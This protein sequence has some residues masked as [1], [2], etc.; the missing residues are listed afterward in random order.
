MSQLRTVVST[1]VCFILVGALLLLGPPASASVTD[2]VASHRAS[3]SLQVTLT[4]GEWPNL[5]PALNTQDTADAAIMNALFGGL[6]EFVTSGKSTRVIPDQATGYQ[7]TN[8]GMALQIRLRHGLR[9]SNGDPMTAAV[10]AASIQR[11]LQPSSACICA[12]DFAAVA[13][14]A[15]SGQDV[16]TLTL[17]RPFP[18]LIYS[19]D[20]FAPNWTA[21][22]AELARVGTAAFGQHPIGAG[23]F[24]VVR[25][26]A[27]SSVLMQANP[28]Y[29]KPGHPLL[30]K[31]TFLSVGSDQSAYDS[32]S[33]GQSQ[34]AG[35]TTVSLIQEARSS[36]AVRAVLSPATGY[37]FVELNS[38]QPP[39]NNI[40]ARE[41]I[42]Y[43]TNPK[44]IVKGLYDNVYQ[45]VQSPTAP[46]ETVYIPKVPRYR[47]Y[48]LQKARALVRQLGGLTVTLGALTNAQSYL[49]EQS[50]LA[51]QWKQAGIT[52]NVQVTSLEQYLQGL[53]SNRW[54]ALDTQWQ[55][56]DPALG[57]PSHFASAAPLSGVKDPVVDTLMN[58]AAA[59]ANHQRQ[60]DIYT[61]LAE[62][63]SSNADVVFLY[64]KP[65]ITIVGKGV[66]GVTD[67]IYGLW[68]NVR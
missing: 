59:T 64:S 30:K 45:V 62:R 35:I 24:E 9:F 20:G 5:D 42:Y 12:P 53:R 18:A 22:L 56:L 26:Q 51:A 33:T 10:V 48:D 46:G 58:Q 52:V 29:W 47:S 3:G 14:V 38:T 7:F 68:E 2:T 23:P 13:S 57:L 37:N 4:S 36:G 16:V 63:M 49:N 41:A 17:S 43:A 21:D 25:N 15:A 60:V 1:V 6:F 28:R 44:A 40:L 55:A 65:Y 27:S 8:G 39:F 11:D 54:Q 19:F 66:H 61:R 67:A 32:V 31:L 34:I 50:A